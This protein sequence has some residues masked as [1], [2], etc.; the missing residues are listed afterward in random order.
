MV[1]LPLELLDPE[2]LSTLSLAQNLRR[3]SSCHKR[4][5]G[6]EAA[7]RYIKAEI[8]NFRINPSGDGLGVAVTLRIADGSYN[9]P[10]ETQSYPLE[11]CVTDTRVQAH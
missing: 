5:R 1:K 3:V 4:V 8:G 10:P 9:Q 11:E 2:P 7:G 6:R